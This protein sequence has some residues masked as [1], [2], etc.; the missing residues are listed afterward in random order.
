[1]G[2]TF[3]FQRSTDCAALTQRRGFTLLEFTIVLCVIGIITSAVW[4]VARSVWQANLA[5]TVTRQLMQS[6]SNIRNQYASLATWP[7]AWPA[8]TD[9]TTSLDAL[10]LFPTDMRSTPMPGGGP[11]NHALSPKFV[12]GSFH[13]LTEPSASGALRAFRVQMKGL[14]SA[15]CTKLLVSLPI[16]E[17]SVNIIQ[18]QVTGQSTHPP[19]AILNGSSGCANVTP[20]TTATAS[21]WCDGNGPINEIDLDFSLQ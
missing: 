9:V 6:V 20:M 21:L 15:S 16:N 17:A 18:I 10:A 8:G 19:C 2:T 13:V 7:A 3:A 5:T 12:G 11:M 1:M 4:L 14:R